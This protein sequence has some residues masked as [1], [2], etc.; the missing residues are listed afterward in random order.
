[1]AIIVAGSV[2]PTGYVRYM[3][4]FVLFHTDKEHLRKMRE[5]I[6]GYVNDTVFLALKIA[7]LGSISHGLPF[8][9]SYAIK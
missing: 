8:L 3:D 7:D 5:K 1:M 6:T 2:K 4:D 9:G